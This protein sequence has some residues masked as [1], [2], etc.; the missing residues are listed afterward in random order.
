MPRI[1]ACGSRKNAYDDFCIA[2]KNG[3]NA[4]L[5]VDSE[6][7]VLAGHWDK[8]WQHLSSRQGDQWEKPANAQ[9]KHCHLM[10]EC[11]EA[12]LVADRETLQAFYGQGFSANAL[13]K[14]ANTEAI[15]K[16][17]LYASLENATRATKTKGKYGKGEHSFKLL[18][19]V[20]ANKVLAASPWAQR[21]VDTT[22]QL[23]GV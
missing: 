21:F 22:K 19:V 23:M 2:V 16:Q 4:L 6:T 1:I 11:M 5:L 3:E 12:W 9:D 13:P 10:V 14:R 15:S 7:A 17:Q 8:P 18:A 20:D